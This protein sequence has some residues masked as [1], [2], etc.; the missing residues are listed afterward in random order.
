MLSATRAKLPPLL[1]LLL[2]AARASESATTT[3]C[4]PPWVKFQTLCLLA[5]CDR[6]TWPEA[7]QRCRS[8]GGDLAWLASKEEH[9]TV[10][11]FYKKNYNNPGCS[12]FY[13][14]WSGLHRNDSGALEWSRLEAGDYRGSI[15]VRKN[16]TYFVINMYGLSL[17]HI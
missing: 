17:I 14:A 8:E 2:T 6:K 13:W 4:A 1:L 10:S 11:K 9:R 7:R 15:I 12:N 16:E 3:T 5:V